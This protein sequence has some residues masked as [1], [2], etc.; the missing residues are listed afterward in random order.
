MN[1]NKKLI[2]SIL[3]LLIGIALILLACIEKV[4][5]YWSGMGSALLVIGALRLLRMHRFQK[6]EAYREKMEIAASDERNHFIRGMAWAWA[7][8]LFVII[9]AV[10]SIA[11]RIIGQEQMSMAASMAVCL[12]ITLFWISFFI[13]RRKY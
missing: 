2:L 1:K 4:D 3:W 6:N 13:L 5:E 8:Y 10:A 7:G 12:L 11:L 9:S